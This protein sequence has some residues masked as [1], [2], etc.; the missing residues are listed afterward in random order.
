MWSIFVPTNDIAYT[1]IN[2]SIIGKL[3]LVDAMP[4]GIIDLINAHLFPSTVY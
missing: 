2:K 1:Y 3:Q 4:P